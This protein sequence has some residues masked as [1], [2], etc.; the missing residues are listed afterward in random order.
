MIEYSDAPVS[1]IEL[2]ALSRSRFLMQR[3]RKLPYRDEGG[4]VNIHLLQ[5]S[6]NDIRAGAACDAEIHAK[7]IAWL[8][9]GQSTLLGSGATK[10]AKLQQEYDEASEADDENLTLDDLL[11]AELSSGRTPTGPQRNTTRQHDF[12]VTRL[13]RRV[14]RK[15]LRAFS[16]E[17]G[18]ELFDPAD[19]DDTQQKKGARGPLGSDRSARAQQSASEEE[20]P[21]GMLDSAAESG[22]D[23]YEVEQVLEERQGRVRLRWAGFGPEHDSWEPESNVSR[24]LL[25]GFRAAKQARHEYAGRDYGGVAGRRPTQLWCTACRAHVHIDSFSAQQRRVESQSGERTCL[26][27]AAARASAKRHRR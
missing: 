4:K 16:G 26:K 25:R 9:H 12:T 18:E 7:A 20:A 10:D 27:H 11:R 5:R 19:S 8:K 6:I 2:T 15:R 21:V 24:E 22:D 3:E 1:S 23:V 17:S 14:S 13:D